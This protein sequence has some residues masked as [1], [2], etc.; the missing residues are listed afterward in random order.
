MGALK[1]L[2][3]TV[4]ES[5]KN[6][7]TVAMYLLHPGMIFQALWNY[8]VI[9]SYWVFLIIALLACVFYA[10]GFKKC[11]KYIPASAAVYIL[12]KAIAVAV[13]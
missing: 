10:L 13:A 4:G 2:L 8:T 11:A 6:I 12:I 1:T 5:L 3:A 9:Y 7:S